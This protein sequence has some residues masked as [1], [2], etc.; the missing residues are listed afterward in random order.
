MDIYQEERP[1]GNFRRFTNN[2]PSTVKIITINP[3]ES[4]SLQSHKERSEFWKVTGGGGVCEVN[5]EKHNFNIGDEKLIP[6]GA[7]HRII[8]GDKGIE[9]LEIALGNFNEEDIVRYEDKYGRV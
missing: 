2:T 9:V 4:L 8:A 6:V 1:W 5:G 3:G 7:K